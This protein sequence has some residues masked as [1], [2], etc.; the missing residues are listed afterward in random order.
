MKR[1]MIL[2]ALG[3][4]LASCVGTKKL[5]INTQPE[6]AEVCINGVPQ[7][8]KTPMD[9]EVEQQKDL[10]IVVSK[11][12]YESTACTVPTR[13]N[14]WLS[15]LWT[16]N[17]PRARFIEEDEVNIPMTRIPSVT[18]FRASKLPEYTGGRLPASAPP[19]LRPLPKNLTN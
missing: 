19:P 2:C 7:P 17:D 1:W 6:G 9:V 14:W 4:S 10:G 12:G 16:K 5:K 3:M 8:G 11:P 15:L 18:G 13:T